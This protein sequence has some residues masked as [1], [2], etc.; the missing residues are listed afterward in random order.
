M[1]GRNSPT[2]TPPDQ[3]VEDERGAQTENFRGPVAES[4]PG[5]HTYSSDQVAEQREAD[6]E[7]NGRD[8]QAAADG[9][10]RL[11]PGGTTEPVEPTEVRETDR[12]AKRWVHVSAMATLSLIVGTLAVAATFTGLLAPLGF[13]GGVLAV[14]IGLLALA[15]VRRPAVTGHTLVM[16]GILFGV[17]AIALSLLAINDSLSWL[18][19]KTDEVSTVHTWLN[20]HIHWLRRW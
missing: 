12:A 3:P 11:M 1:F 14:L 15:A 2:S 13:A 9:D 10:T 5:G 8:E 4:A 7:R 16:L 20:N 19:N 17:V 18:S 6:A